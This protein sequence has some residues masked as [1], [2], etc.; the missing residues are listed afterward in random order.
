MCLDLLNILI[1]KYITNFTDVKMANDIYSANCV[2]TGLG[3]A[4]VCIIGSLIVSNHNLKYS[5]I[6]FGAISIIVMIGILIFMKTKWLVF[7]YLL[8]HLLSFLGKEKKYG[9]M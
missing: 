8:S 9:Y 1:K 6:I 5:M 2:V 7:V 4:L 3:N